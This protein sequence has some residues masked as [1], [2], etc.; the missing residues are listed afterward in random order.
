MM[1]HELSAHYS[2]GFCLRAIDI[3]KTMV[4]LLRHWA[5]V[6]HLPTPMKNRFEV[7]FHVCGTIPLF[8][9]YSEVCVNESSDIAINI[10][11]SANL[12]DDC[13]SIRRID[14]RTFA[15]RSIGII[16]RWIQHPSAVPDR[17]DWIPIRLIDRSV[18]VTWPFCQRTSPNWMWFPL[19][20]EESFLN[21]DA[22]DVSNVDDFLS[23][24]YSYPS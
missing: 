4:R 13:W 10:F 8:W 7:A 23:R 2:G 1:R 5:L 17:Y 9:F 11:I 22:L 24:D 19:L 18:I 14:L 15:I 6:D 16:I 12:V 3:M 21:H 20:T